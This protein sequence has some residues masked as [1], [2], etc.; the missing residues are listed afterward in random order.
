MKLIEVL[1]HLSCLSAAVGQATRKERDAKYDSIC[2]DKI[3]EEEI[4]PGYTVKY[5]CDRVGDYDSK[6]RAAATISEC[7]E[8]CQ[9]TAGCTGSTW[10]RNTGD[11]LLSGTSVA[12][13]WPGAILMEEVSPFPEDDDEDD[14]FPDASCEDEVEELNQCQTA[15]A[16]C[17]QG[18]GS[19]PTPGSGSGPGSGPDLSGKTCMFQV[20]IAESLHTNRNF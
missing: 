10:N 9:D 1:L 5:T 19:G 14:P 3:L 13:D 16:Q 12:K 17:Q 18:S 4:S 15:L 8:R 2:P 11:C 7:A 6:S 20:Y